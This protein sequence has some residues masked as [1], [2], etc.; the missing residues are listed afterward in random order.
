MDVFTLLL[1]LDT[2]NLK[3]SDGWYIL[4]CSKSIVAGLRA[5]GS[6]YNVDPFLKH[7][8]IN[9]PNSAV[10]K[11]AAFLIFIYLFTD[12]SRMFLIVKFLYYTKYLQNATFKLYI[13]SE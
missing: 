9:C 6:K 12:S 11:C 10:K 8:V 1:C 13:F 4:Y 3:G 7:L 2:L 5:L